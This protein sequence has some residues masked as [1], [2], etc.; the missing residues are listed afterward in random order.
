M[1]GHRAATPLELLFDLTFVITFALASSKFAHAL[2]E[3]HYV[4]GLLGFGFGFAER[5]CP[6]S[7]E[8]PEGMAP[9]IEA[10]R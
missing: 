9:S 8:A 1:E 6:P 4:A 5:Y 7:F 3:R 2:A 10:I